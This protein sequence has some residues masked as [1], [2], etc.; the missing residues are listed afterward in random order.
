MLFV[1]PLKC[2]GG[3]V[4]GRSIE[5]FHIILHDLLATRMAPITI[6]R[7]LYG[8]QIQQRRC[9]GRRPI[10]PYFIAPWNGPFREWSSI[11]G[12]GRGLQSAR[13]GA[14]EVLPLQKK[15]MCR[16]CSSDP[17]G[18]AQIVLRWVREILAILKGGHKKLPPFKKGDEKVLPFLEGGITKVHDMQTCRDQSLIT[19]R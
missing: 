5:V 2:G 15:G 16:K 6:H 19:R 9:I 7:R 17:N 3:R 11:T 14:S 12:R 4:G 8:I 18:E 13:T 10:L 1:F